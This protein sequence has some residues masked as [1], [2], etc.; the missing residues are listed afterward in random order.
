M[1]TPN[2][3]WDSTSVTHRMAYF[4]GIRDLYGSCIFGVHS[5]FIHFETGTMVMSL[6]KIWRLLLETLFIY[7]QVDPIFNGRFT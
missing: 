1:G 6:L 5:W 3:E 4:L 2:P 7:R